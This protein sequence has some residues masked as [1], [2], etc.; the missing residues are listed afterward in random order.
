VIESSPPCSPSTTRCF[1][2]QR[3]ALTLKLYQQNRIRKS[4]QFQSQHRLLNFLL[5]SVRK[6]TIDHRENG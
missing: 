1:E 6:T 4:W 5:L 3:L 2:G